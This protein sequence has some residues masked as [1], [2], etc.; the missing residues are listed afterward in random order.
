MWRPDPSP[1][2]HRLD[3]L[4]TEVGDLIVNGCSRDAAPPA[5][6]WCTATSTPT[7]RTVLRATAWTAPVVAVTATAPA[8]AAS[9]APSGF[10]L[11]AVNNSTASADDARR[12]TFTVTNPAASSIVAT[13]FIP[14]SGPGAARPYAF[15]STT[16]WVFDFGDGYFTYTC[17]IPP[18][19]DSAAVFFEWSSDSTTRET[20]TVSASAPEFAAVA[21]AVTLPFD[22]PNA[23]ARRVARSDAVLL[24]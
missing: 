11:R 5:V 15:D 2:V 22:V 6:G 21:V 16:P 1:G 20:V 18:M 19:S 17:T 4:F 13:I 10:V 7:R 24:H 3:A 8:F 23:A 9:T 12:V 14:E